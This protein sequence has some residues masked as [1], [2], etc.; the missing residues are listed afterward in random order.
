MTDL[1]TSGGKRACLCAFYSCWYEQVNRYLA[2]LTSNL[3]YLHGS[4]I[5]CW[6]VFESCCRWSV[7]EFVRWLGNILE[8]EKICKK[9]S[10]IPE[11]LCVFWW[12]FLEA[13]EVLSQAR[14]SENFLWAPALGWIFPN[15]SNRK[16]DKPLHARDSTLLMGIQ[17]AV[18]LLDP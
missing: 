13:A 9:T 12:L 15:T 3:A 8:E 14:V 2:W 6:N 10:E 11:A 5:A 17:C 18:P 16:E 1:L 7:K 4:V